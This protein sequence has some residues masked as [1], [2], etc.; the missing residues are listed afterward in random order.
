MSLNDYIEKRDR[1]NKTRSVFEPRDIDSYSDIDDEKKALIR[2]MIPYLGED[3]YINLLHIYNDFSTP[4]Y[5]IGY[6]QCEDE[7]GVRYLDSIRVSWEEEYGYGSPTCVLPVAEFN[8]K[9][10]GLNKIG[11]QDYTSI[12]LQRKKYSSESGDIEI[13]YTRDGNI[14]VNGDAAC[15][16]A[17]KSIDELGEQLAWIV[18][19]REESV[20]QKNDFYNRIMRKNTRCGR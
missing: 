14:F 13:F 19:Y 7:N 1:V 17:Y 6:V 15:A 12:K 2:D 20:K 3:S 18:K 16:L 8:H 9:Y 10:Q 5:S 11:S 4:V